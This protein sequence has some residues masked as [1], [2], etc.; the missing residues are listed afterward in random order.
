MT[1]I[2]IRKPLNPSI[3]SD[4]EEIKK[5][6]KNIKII[7]F[8]WD[9]TLHRDNLKHYVG[10]R[11][12]Y[13]KC[14]LERYGLKLREWYNFEGI[15]KHLLR[16]PMSRKAGWQYLKYRIRGINIFK[17]ILIYLNYEILYNLSS[18]KYNFL[19]PGVIEMLRDLK[20]K[21]YLLGIATNK[22]A[23]IVKRQL[24]FLKIMKL[25]S[26]ILG[27]NNV[28]R[29]KPHPEMI[30]KSLRVIR[31][32]QRFKGFNKFKLDLAQLQPKNIL[33]V[34]DNPKDDVIAGLSAGAI[35][36]LV[37]YKGDLSKLKR[38]QIPHIFLDSILQLKE[39]F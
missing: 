36:C 8:D 19:I 33:M 1:L 37:N 7:L 26:S 5:L 16:G 20:G 18:L 17:R 29:M 27:S 6:L 13:F 24:K 35:T 12:I 30:F 25:F 11:E 32:K 21:G 4:L 3:A 34:G 9:G 38:N 14:N 39:I 2:A 22:G 15:D 28:L 10:M 23:G 31:R